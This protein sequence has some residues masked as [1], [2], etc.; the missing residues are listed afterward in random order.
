LEE[1]VLQAYLGA[2]Q[3][4][5]GPGFDVRASAEPSGAATAAASTSSPARR[6][7]LRHSEGFGYG[8][9]QS[10]DRQRE[11]RPAPTTRHPLGW[12]SRPSN[13]GDWWNKL[14]GL[15]LTAFAV[16]LGAPFWFDLLNR[17]MNIR[18][19][20]KSPEEKAKPPDATK[21]A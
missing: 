1:F 8:A 12:K 21:P 14:A 3:F 18:A 20:G 13:A 19:G 6:G 11:N 15:A 7:L 9:S 5:E 10:T 16:S 17:F 4:A 2:Q